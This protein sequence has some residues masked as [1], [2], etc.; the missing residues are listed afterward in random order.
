VYHRLARPR[1]S[2]RN[3]AATGDL[4]GGLL[5]VEIGRHITAFSVDDGGNFLVS[6]TTADGGSVLRWLSS[7][8]HPLW[9]RRI[10]DRVIALDA[11]G[12]FLGIGLARPSN[13]LR[14][15]A[16]VAILTSPVR[17]SNAGG[18]ACD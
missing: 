4:A 3:V 6:L 13:E 7:E 18:V 2:V 12:R 11:A 9:E 5:P 17:D 15:G 8:G 1:H 10:V 14:A 16:S